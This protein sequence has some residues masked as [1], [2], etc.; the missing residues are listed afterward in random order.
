MKKILTLVPLIAFLVFSCSQKEQAFQFEKGTPAYE[1]AEKLSTILP[2]LEPE[3]NNVLVK[4]DY[5]DVTVGETI[6]G[7][8]QNFG[9]NANQLAEMDTAIVKS[10]VMSNARA[11]AEKKVLEYN[12]KKAGFK[13]DTAEVDSI[14]QLQYEATGGEEAFKQRLAE[15]DIAI[16]TVYE[17]IVSGMLINHYL[18]SEIKNDDILITEEEIRAEFVPEKERTA[19]HI[20][21][22][23]RED[24]TEQQ[25][26]ADLKKI[27]EILAK[28]KL[29]ED[30]G[31]LAKKYS[32]CPSKENGGDLGS[33]SRGTMVKE[34]DEAVF[35]MQIGEISNVVETQFGYHIIKL[36]DIILN[37]Y[38][39]M[40]EKLREKVLS[41]KK[42]L[43]YEKFLTDL[44]E[45]AHFEET[46]I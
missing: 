28:A 24:S 3:K 19:Q 27:N 42:R 37:D 33:F 35:N 8:F 1:L 32:D 14:M 17:S 6:D 11:I 40:K 18:D 44:K 39:T 16:E 7:I 38:D 41:D 20:L 26:A 46:E 31:E 36:N 29:G 21:I 25:K 15:N 4:T 43:A 9:K 2:V 30:F 22:D 5:F 10:I 23:T 13:T 45:K 12:A 34:F